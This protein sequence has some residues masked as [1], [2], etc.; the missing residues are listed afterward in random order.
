MRRTLREATR[1]LRCKRSFPF[2]FDL[3]NEFFKV[4]HIHLVLF[5][6]LGDKADVG[7]VVVTGD[8]VPDGSPVIVTFRERRAV[9]ERVRHRLALDKSLILKE[10]HLCRHG[11][12]VRLRVGKR[13]DDVTDKHLAFGPDDVHH[14]FLF[15]SKSLFH[16]SIL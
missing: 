10:F 3:R 6:E 15:C 11:V 13:R 9:L 4:L 1:S 5:D 2:A 16:C 12:V 14:L 7:V 8:N